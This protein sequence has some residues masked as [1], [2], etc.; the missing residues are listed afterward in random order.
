VRDHSQID[1]LRSAMRSE[2]RWSPPP[3]CPDG[4]GLWTLAL[5]AC[6]NV[7]RSVSCG[8]DI[9]A[10]GVF[11]LGML[12]EFEPRLRA[13]GPWFYRGLHWETGLVGQVLYLEAEAVG[14]RATGIGCFLDDLM[15]EVLGL[16]GNAWQTLYHFAVG[17]AVDDAR[18]RTLDPYAHR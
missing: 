14:L 4:L 12:A 6:D 2:F 8:Q 3:G 10:D 15:H 7:A 13:H 9:A 5:G 11:A 1:S 18:L 17:G 16:S